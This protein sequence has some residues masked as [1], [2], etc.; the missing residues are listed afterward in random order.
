M[1]N[2]RDFLKRTVLA[3][4]GAMMIPEILQACNLGISNENVAS[5]LKFSPNAVVLFQGD[6]ITDAGRKREDENN[7][8]N[9][10]MLGNGYPMFTAAELLSKYAGYNLQIYNR[11]ISGNK[12]F[13]LRERWEKDCFSLKPDVLSILIGIN[14]YWHMKKHGYE[15]TLTKFSADYRD[16][17]TS[18]KK[19][20]PGVRLVI[21]EPFTIK[22]G[23]ALD[24]TWY[25]E[26]ADYRETVKTLAKEFNAILVPFQSVFDKALEKAPV[27]YWGADG[28]H[29]S[30]AGAMLMAGAWLKAT[31]L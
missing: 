18:T 15:G 23:T 11:G 29:P 8:N 16:L 24:D 31:G 21:C 20:L 4:A 12:V 19:Q 9:Q 22:G 27:A 30:M 26:F 5:G 3:G 13:Q 25:P 1:S 28:V 14:D 17:L 10:K 7:A 6:S 2:R